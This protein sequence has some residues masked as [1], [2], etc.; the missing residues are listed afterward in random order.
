VGGGGGVFRMD[1]VDRGPDEKDLERQMGYDAIGS[2]S[3]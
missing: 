3:I 2:N 1:I